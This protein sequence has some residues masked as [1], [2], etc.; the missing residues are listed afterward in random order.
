MLVGARSQR[1]CQHEASGG[2]PRAQELSSG[3]LRRRMIDALHS[4][5]RL[6]GWTTRA[7]RHRHVDYLG[8][9]QR[10]AIAALRDLFAAAEAV[11]NDEGVGGRRA[12]GRQQPA[13][14]DG[15]RHVIVPRFESER[16][17][18]PAA[19]GVEDVILHTKS[20][21]QSP[22]GIHLHERLLM[23]MPVNERAPFHPA[24][25]TIPTTSCRH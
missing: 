2:Q 18:H 10:A 8:Q 23:T 5:W 21:Q 16:A 7:V 17:G 4:F 6:G 25:M 11:G 13:F 20:L 15:E 3:Q 19:A 1:E 14:T 22:V 12:D 24:P 9:V